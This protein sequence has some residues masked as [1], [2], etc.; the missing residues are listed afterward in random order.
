MG[1]HYGAT[2]K[3][4]C[5]VGLALLFLNPGKAE[6]QQFPSGFYVIINS[7]K[8]CPNWLSSHVGPKTFCLPKEPVITEAD[9]ESVSE[10]RYDSFLQ[11]YILLK[12]TA[13]GFKSLKF[14]T[15]RLP[16]SKLALVIDDQVAGVF[17]NVDKNISQTI[18]IKGGINAPEVLWIHD[19]LKKKSP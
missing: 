16:D 7:R 6:A 2:M 19:R 18:P 3:V 10:V 9:F 12:L 4:A 13:S 14:L 11:K 1:Y 15:Q 17:D 5:G 8:N